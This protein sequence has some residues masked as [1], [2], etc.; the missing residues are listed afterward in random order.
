MLVVV[1]LPRRS[2]G[3]FDGR[4]KIVVRRIAGQG[5]EGPRRMSELMGPSEERNRCAGVSGV[6]SESGDAPARGVGQ[7]LDVIQSVAASFEAG[8]IAIPVL[9]AF[10]IVPELDVGVVKR[11]WDFRSS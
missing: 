2:Q 6:V 3:G 11:D 10:V 4:D 7:E 5:R 9:L 8:E 1:P